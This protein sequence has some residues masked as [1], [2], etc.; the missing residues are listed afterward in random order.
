MIINHN[1]VSLNT[2]SKLGQANKSQANSMEKLSSGLRINRA[3]DDAAGL[4][5]SEKMRAQVRRLAQ[6]HRNMQDGVS[7]IQTAEGGLNEIHALLQRGRELA[8]QAKND[9]LVESDRQS[10]QGELDQIGEEVDRVANTTEFNTINLLNVTSSTESSDQQ[11]AVEAL[12]KYWLKNSED[13][14]A[15][16]Y[17]LQAG[18]DDAPLEIQFIQN[19]GDG[20]VAWVQGSVYTSG[21]DGRYFNQKL[22]LDMS[23]FSPISMPNGGGSW[24]SNDRIIAHEMAHAVMGRTTNMRDLPTWFIEGT[25]EFIAGADERLENDLAWAGN[26][27]EALKDNIDAWDSTS[28]D[29]SASYAAVKYLDAKIAG[30]IK[31]LFNQIKIGG[32]EETLDQALTSL[33]GYNTAGFI[34]DFKANATL[35]NSGITLGDADTGA[36][37]SGDDYTTVP[38]TINADLENPLKAFVEKWPSFPAAAQN[39]SLG[40]G[41]FIKLG[42][43]NATS[44]ALGINTVDTLNNA[45]DNIALF[46]GAISYVSGE[47]SRFGAY[48][49]RLEKAMSVTSISEENLTSAESRIRDVDM[50]KEMMSQTK[51]SILAQAAQAMLTQANQQPQSILQLLG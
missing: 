14:I 34:A 47:R 9:T 12:Q 11:L 16:H 42:L 24:I 46:D 13:L 1:I 19:S 43:T 3:G 45:T 2:H 21:T 5:I 25:A 44:E 38:D 20:R 40:V 33:L 8:V 17:G 7:L 48:Q 22:V 49:N 50:A 32:I 37:G 26:D 36:I 28:A 15:T 31:A 29:Y 23:D 41:P 27:F 35:A 10:I 6:E 18:L 4:A 30:G 51:S 39:S